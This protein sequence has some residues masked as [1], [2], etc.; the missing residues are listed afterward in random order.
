MKITYLFA[1]RTKSVV[2]VEE[3]WGEIILDFDRQEYNNNHKE[4]RRHIHLDTELEHSDWLTCDDEYITALTDTPENII[5]LR[6]AIS[7][8]KPNQ[9]EMLK[10][11]FFEGL[12]HEEY[13]RKIGVSRPAVTQQLQTIFKKI[14]KVF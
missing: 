6:K 9:Q 11:I 1:D 5:K 3:N 13:A 4:T 14:K 2:E 8:L 10:A 7:T 12:T